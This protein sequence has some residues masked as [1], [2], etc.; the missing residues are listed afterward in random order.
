MLNGLVLGEALFNDAVAIVLVGCIE[1]YAA[2]SFTNGQKLEGKALGYAA[3][4]F[5]NVVFGSVGLGSM[6]G[7]LTAVLTKFTRICDFP[8]LETSLFTLMSYTAYLLAEATGMSG[9]VSLLFCGICQAHYTYPNLSQESKVQTRKLFE[10]L[11]FL[12]ENFI[13]T[14]IGVSMFTSYNHK[15]EPAF[16]LGAFAGIAVA[17]AAN[18]YPLSLL[19]NCGRRRKIPCNVSR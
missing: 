7:F 15:F 5:V 6:V 16:I 17:R 11:N 13:F 1:E 10:T 4:T 3:L 12:A 19:V 8:L 2:I 9:I 18:V 14:Y